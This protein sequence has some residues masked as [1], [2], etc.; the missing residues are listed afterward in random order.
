M[1]KKKSVDPLAVLINGKGD[2]RNTIQTEIGIY[3][4]ERIKA[5]QS[6]VKVRINIAGLGRNLL[7]DTKE[8]EIKNGEKDEWLMRFGEYDLIIYKKGFNSTPIYLEW[9]NETTF[10][11]QFRSRISDTSNVHVTFYGD[12][13][14]L[15]KQRYFA[16]MKIRIKYVRYTK[17]SDHQ[18]PTVTPELLI[19]RLNLAISKERHYEVFEP[20]IL[21]VE[22]VSNHEIIAT[23]SITGKEKDDSQLMEFLVWRIEENWNMNAEVIVEII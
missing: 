22:T 21:S 20:K 15:S 18:T 23:L 3:A 19:N 7:I 12:I 10:R 14:Q 8:I 11:L 4:L 17:E 6:D 9:A 1:F 13:G 5:N 16:D 2:F